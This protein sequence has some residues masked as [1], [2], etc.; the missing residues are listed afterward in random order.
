MASGLSAA[1]IWSVMSGTTTEN[2]LVIA[3]EGFF[4]AAMDNQLD[5]D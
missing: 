1:S 2:V 5:R 3:Y 4:D